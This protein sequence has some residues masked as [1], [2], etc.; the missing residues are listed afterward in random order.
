MENGCCEWR[1]TVW[2]LHGE[3]KQDVYIQWRVGNRRTE[4]KNQ[5]GAARTLVFSRCA[6]NRSAKMRVRAKR[7]KSLHPDHFYPQA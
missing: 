6:S 2:I 1:V 5:G 3:E 7:R 4:S